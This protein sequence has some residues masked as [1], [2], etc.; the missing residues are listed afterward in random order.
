MFL[1]LT[2]FLSTFILILFSPYLWVLLFFSLLLHLLPLNVF[3]YFCFF[4]SVPFFLYLC[5]AISSSWFCICL[6]RLSFPLQS[7]PVSVL[8]CISS[9]IPIICFFSFFFFLS[10][11][12]IIFLP[13]FLCSYS[14][15]LFPLCI[16]V[17]SYCSLVLSST[18]VSTFFLS[19]LPLLFFC[20]VMSLPL[21]LCT[22]FSSDFS[23]ISLSLCYLFHLSRCFFSFSLFLTFLSI[24]S[25]KRGN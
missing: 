3:Q 7:L 19:L 25:T 4:S 15:F 6:H 23:P 10:L 17:T 9:S 20:V 13:P 22:F 21:C 11:H 18:F 16:Y 1:N 2:L 5:M 14:F 8:T 12:V 24:F